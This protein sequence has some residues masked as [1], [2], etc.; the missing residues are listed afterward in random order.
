[1]LLYTIIR[2]NVSLQGSPEA[3]SGPLP[4]LSADPTESQSKHFSLIYAMCAKVCSCRNQQNAMICN[5]F[6]HSNASKLQEHPRFFNT[7]G[8]PGLPFWPWAFKSLSD[9][10]AAHAQPMRVKHF[11]RPSL[12]ISGRLGPGRSG[13]CWRDKIRVKNKCA[14][15]ALLRF[16]MTSITSPKKTHARPL[17]FLC[18]PHARALFYNQN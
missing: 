10:C 9:P 17:F 8:C 4:A 5:T 2:I 14:D 12:E 16:A 13:V 1:M 3:K 7:C 11:R 15:I 18:D 6:G